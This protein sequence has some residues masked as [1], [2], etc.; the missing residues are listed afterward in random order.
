MM[1]TV[2]FEVHELVF[3]LSR[4]HIEIT[5]PRQRRAGPV[6]RR[7][8]KS[9]PEFLSVQLHFHREVDMPSPLVVDG[10]TALEVTR[11]IDLL[12][13]KLVHIKD[14][15]GQFLQKLPDGR[16]IDTK[17]W[18]DWEWTH[19]IGLLGLSQLHALTG[20]PKALNII[21]DWFDPRLEESTTKNINTMCAMLTLAYLYEQSGNRSYLPWLG[22]WGEWAM[23]DLPRTT[24]GGFQHVTYEHENREQLWDDT[25]M[26]TVIPLAKIGQIL[27]R[28]HYLEEAK[29]QFLLHIQ[30]LFDTQTGLFFHGWQFDASG[31]NGLGHNFARARWARGNS[32]LTLAI[33][34]F[35]ELLDL[36]PQDG[37]RMYL[38]GVL[39]AQCRALRGLQA[40]DGM[41]RTLLD[42]SEA[43]GSY[44]EASA[45]AGFACGLLKSI[46]KRYIG[47]EYKE[48]A[49]K[50]ARAVLANIDEHGELRQVSFGTAMGTDL[51]HYV[52]IT[53]TS[54]PY[55]QAMAVLALIEILWLFR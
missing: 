34:G 48:T 44:R 24:F 50:A 4:F 41:W 53:K 10:L 32:W 13:D 37:L 47:V 36:P 52:D 29:R 2:N 16:S 31:P 18:N 25:L 11:Q 26:M 17:S 42:V 35:I 22:A 15:S 23:H 1:S 40:D 19:G 9:F 45:T 14:D 20:S 33:P 54:M 8:S 55:G 51:Q 5:L 30:Y 39:E 27:D 7:S 43:D 38:I 46:R 28:P 12:V 21:Q 3:N 6:G 49:M